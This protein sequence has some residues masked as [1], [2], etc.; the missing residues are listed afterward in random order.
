M[1]LDLDKFKAVNDTLRHPA[2]VP[3]L[4]D[5]APRLKASVRETDGLARLPGDECAIIQEGAPSQHEGASAL[6]L[7]IINS[8]TQP[9][10]LSGQRASVGTSIGIVLAPEHGADPEELLKRADLALYN[11]K[12]GGRNDFRIFQPEMLE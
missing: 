9:F 1:M 6:A 7:R 10:D 11:V 5:V 3:V 8:I 12:A 4:G 2:G